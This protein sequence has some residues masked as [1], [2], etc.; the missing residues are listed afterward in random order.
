MKSLLGIF[1]ICS[2][3]T[4]CGS[5]QPDCL[6]WREIRGSFTN[7]DTQQGLRVLRNAEEIDQ[8]VSNRQTRKY[9]KDLQTFKTDG[10]K[11]HEQQFMILGEN[12]PST[13]TQ[14][15]VTVD[16]SKSDEIAVIYKMEPKGIGL[17]VIGQPFWIGVFPKSCPVSFVAK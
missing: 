12:A 13:S 5:L 7:F 1:L 11:S 15:S 16:T 8:H 14:L 6:N 9:M 2:L 3:L 4:G 10:L 17:H